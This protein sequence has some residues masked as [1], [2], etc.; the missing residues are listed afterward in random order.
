MAQGFRRRPPMLAHGLGYVSG[1]NVA[2]A[3][4]QG[5]SQKDYIIQGDMLDF[6]FFGFRVLVGII[7]TQRRKDS[8]KVSQHQGSSVRPGSTET[9]QV[10]LCVHMTGPYLI[11]SGV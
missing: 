3:V 8:Y 4:T 11:S 2:H 9:L 7:Q 1:L 5:V 6:L 10:K